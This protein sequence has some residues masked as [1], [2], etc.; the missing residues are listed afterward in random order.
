MVKLLRYNSRVFVTPNRA[1][2]IYPSDSGFIVQ[3]FGVAETINNY[4]TLPEAITRATQL[5]CQ[6]GDEWEDR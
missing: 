6:D 3:Q 4:K 5:C 2:I 1:V